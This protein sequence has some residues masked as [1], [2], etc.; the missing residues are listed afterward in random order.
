MDALQERWGLALAAGLALASGAVPALAQ[1][2]APPTWGTGASTEVPPTAPT[3]PSGAGE[4]G[5]FEPTSTSVRPS[6]E[7]RAEPATAAVRYVI[8]RIELRGNTRTKARVIL[9]YLPFAKGDVINVDE[10]TIELSRFR[11][12][13]TGFFRDV[14]YSLRKGSSRGSVVFVVDV[15]ERNTVVVNGVWMGLSADVD[16]RGHAR[17]LTAYGG[18]EAAETNLAGTGVTLGGAA[19]IAQDQLALRLR[20]L[21][22]ALLGTPWMT[23]FS[24]L[25]NSAREFFGNGDVD[26]SG[27]AGNDERLTDYAVVAYRRFGGALG[28]GRDLSVATQAWGQFRLER[29]DAQLPAFASHLRGDRREPVEFD[30]LRGPSTLATLRL[31]LIHDTRDH[32]WLP[33]RGWYVSSAVELAPEWLGSDYSYQRVDLGVSRWWTLPWR[34]HVLRLELLGGAIA[35]DAPFFEQYY[36]ADFSDFLPTRVLG[37]NFD[38]RASPNFLGTAIA[39]TRMGHYVGKLAAEYRIPLY[40]GH[41]SVFGIDLFGSAGAYVLARAGDLEVAPG[42]YSG[43]SLVPVDLTANLGVRMDTSAGGFVFAL[44]NVIG[45][46]PMRSGRP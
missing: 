13:G 27:G 28:L 26:Y 19:G 32:P 10:P 39:E 25:H 41:R 40:R 33:T 21:D 18:V 2:V 8:E 11:L 16:A 43:F 35:G 34:A 20:Y 7:P 36:A 15:Q 6:G 31:H 9:R 3:A 38:R 45:F 37:L 30:V 22:P 14:Q 24:L 23:S 44:S 46:V 42:G 1:P 29:V 12:L 17:P 5:G 4:E